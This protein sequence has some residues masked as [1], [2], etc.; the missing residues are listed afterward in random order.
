MVGFVIGPAPAASPLPVVPDY[1]GANLARVVP[2]FMASPGAR[3]A[4]VPAPA[5]AADQV[6]LLVLDG[7]GWLQ[8]QERLHLAPN[9]AGLEGRAVTTVA[10]STTA[11]A[12]TSLAV[13]APPACHGVV[14]YRLV[15]DGPTGPEVM[16]VLRWKTPSGDAREF[17]DPASFQRVDPFGGVPVP[18]VSKAEFAGT[19]FTVAHQ[20]GARQFGWFEPSGMVVD[21][22]Q[23][24]AAGEQFVYAYYEGIDKVAHGNGMGPHYDAELV[25]ADRLVGDLLEALP[26]GTALVVTA[27]H[28]QVQVGARG[29]VELRAKDFPGVRSVSGEARFRWLHLEDGHRAERVAASVRERF[30]HQAWVATYAEVERDGWLGEPGRS[31]DAEVRRRLGDIAL[32][33]FDPVA[34]V[35][36]GEEDR[37]ERKLECRH[38]SMTE[39]EMLVPLLAGRGRGRLAR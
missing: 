22:A 38:G 23:L 6:V 26:A 39:D 20:R 2:A 9:L 1:T 12:L 37:H 27:D 29:M 16:N 4:W 15:V 34:Y 28:G 14:G 17:V 13:G 19:G 7:L 10:P 11:A 32:L 33:P 21:V 31:I 3:P 24:V 8:L 36:P 5:A 35:E 25:A 18:V 30:A